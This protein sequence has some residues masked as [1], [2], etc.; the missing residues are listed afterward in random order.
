MTRHTKKLSGLG[1]ELVNVL[2]RVSRAKGNWDHLITEALTILERARPAA[3][4]TDAPRIT[5]IT[6]DQK[7]NGIHNAIINLAACMQDLGD[8]IAALEDKLN[9]THE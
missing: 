9:A 5:P 3:E 4:F 1:A 2:V 6:L 7:L 8:G